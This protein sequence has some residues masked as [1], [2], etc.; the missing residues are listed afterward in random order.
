MILREFDLYGSK[1]RQLNMRIR[2]SSR[3]ISALF[4]RC[5]DRGFKTEGI[6]KVEAHFS[7]DASRDPHEVAGVASVPVR[8]DPI[9]FLE[10]TGRPFRRKT[11][12]IILA[13][14]LKAARHYGWSEDPFR[15]AHRRAIQ[16]GLCNHWTWNQTKWNPGRK[17]KAELRCEHEPEYL[18]MTLALVDREGKSTVLSEPIEELP[19]EFVFHNYFGRLRWVAPDKVTWFNKNGVEVASLRS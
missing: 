11:V 1:D 4:E 3:C 9:S 15:A 5:F 10:L 19:S 6:W 7:T 16:K 2:T 14:S 18:H 8:E 17:L 12:D 13:A